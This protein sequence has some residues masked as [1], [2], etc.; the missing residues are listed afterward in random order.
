MKKSAG[1][2]G[3]KEELAKEVEQFLNKKVNEGYQRKGSKTNMIDLINSIL[4]KIEPYQLNI[5]NQT[6]KKQK[7]TLIS[8]ENRT[9]NAQ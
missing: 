5:T 7:A 4:I 9:K 8:E 6:L 2:G 3:M 1:F